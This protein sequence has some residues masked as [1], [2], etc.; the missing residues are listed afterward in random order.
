MPSIKVTR[1]GVYIPEL[2]NQG[3]KEEG[4]IRIHWRFLSFLEQQ[5]LLE[6]GDLEKPFAYEGKITAAMITKIE[7]LSIDDGQEERGITTGEQLLTEP[8]LES[9]SMEVW[10][11]LRKQTAVDKKK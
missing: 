3:R 10:L 1:G 7:N 2:F 6:S 4:K 8:T 5:E 9:L 11:H